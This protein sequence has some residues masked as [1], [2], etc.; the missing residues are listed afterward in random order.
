M[1]ET[2]KDYIDLGNAGAKKQIDWKG[3]MRKKL[4]KAEQDGTRNHVPFDYRNAWK[5]FQE[6]AASLFRTFN[7]TSDDATRQQIG[8]QI[9]RFIDKFDIKYYGDLS[10]MKKVATSEA[11][12]VNRRT[13]VSELIGYH[14]DYV[15][16]GKGNHI[17]VYVPVN[18]WKDW[19]EKHGDKKKVVARE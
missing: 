14:V 11:W 12:D 6:G 10:R 7:D 19:N 3:E 13:K 2:I 18:E 1:S 15:V 16:V 4:I 5:D 9:N 8:A 17:S